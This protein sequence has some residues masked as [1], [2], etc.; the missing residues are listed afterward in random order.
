MSSEQAEFV[1]KLLRVLEGE[2][3]EV[4]EGEVLE[5]LEAE[6]ERL[7]GL[8]EELARLKEETVRELERMNAQMTQAADEIRLHLR[9]EKVQ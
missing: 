3:S 2:A 8:R 5:A 7:E 9:S 6:N 1:G 4:E